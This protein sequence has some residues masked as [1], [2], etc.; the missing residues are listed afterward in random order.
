MCDLI[1]KEKKDCEIW[2]TDISDEVIK[3]NKKDKKGIKFFHGYAG[4]Q[5]FLPSN[6]FDVVFAGELIEHMDYPEKLFEEAYRILGVSKR[7]ATGEV[8]RVYHRLAAQF[9]PDAGSDLEI[10]QRRLSE[11]AFIRI[12]NAYNTIMAEREGQRKTDDPETD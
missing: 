9:H 3:A 12:Q 7:A 4:H 5:D 2:G 1:K 8:K 10:D 11:E 6:Y